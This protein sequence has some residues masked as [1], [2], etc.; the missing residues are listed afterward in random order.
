MMLAR[1]AKVALAVAMACSCWLPATARA[2]AALEEAPGTV[3]PSFGIAGVV[4]VPSHQVYPPSGPTG[5]I[6]EDMVIGPD[7]E[8]L[9]LESLQECQIA[10]RVRF[11]VQRYLPDGKLDQSFGREGVSDEAVVDTFLKPTLIGRFS[12]GSLAVGPSGEPVLAT[13]DQGDIALFRFNRSGRLAPD[14]GSGGAVRIDF[15]GVESRPQV[16]VLA[17]E[18]IVVAGG[19][20]DGPRTFVVLA[21]LRPDGEFDP[22]FGG[23]SAPGLLGRTVTPGRFPG[24]IALWDGGS[25]AL[26]GAGC[27]GPATLR[28]VYTARRR[29]DGS[30]PS[31][32][33]RLHRPWRYL[34]VGRRAW[35]SSVLPLPRGRLYLVGGTGR[36]LFA[37]RLR[38]SGR[39]DK[40]FGRGGWTYFPKMSPGASPAVVDAARRLYVAGYRYPGEEY[41]VNIGFLARTT[42][43][44]RRDLN[45]GSRSSGY[46]YLS[47]VH[48]P[49][50]LG[51]QS[52]GG[53]VAFGE[54]AYE[55]IRSCRLP[56]WALTRVYTGSSPSR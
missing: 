51:F 50:A 55:C 41:A 29:S 46:A 32:E 10:C 33:R 28:S 13:T 23:G 47:Q 39:L 14:F 48:E 38:P 45:W 15:G 9:V 53:L 12:F 24:A 1:K 30:L 42:P 6:A 17:D 22:G 26:A 11:F 5:P 35:V 7:D 19:S 52:N 49:L 4:D 44:G 2:H 40:T 36:A 3:D 56:G 27:C 8:I 20:A 31:I 43:R 54:S 34:R 37:A 25:I 16:A 18:R 21:R